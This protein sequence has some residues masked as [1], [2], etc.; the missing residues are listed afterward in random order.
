LPGS[1]GHRAAWARAERATGRLCEMI[2]GPERS[3]SP[4]P[5]AVGESAQTP[6]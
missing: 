1:P 3:V 6:D 5:R 4:L 2:D